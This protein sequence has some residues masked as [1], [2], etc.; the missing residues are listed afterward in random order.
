M[1]WFMV[2]TAIGVP[3]GIYAGKRRAV[4][5]RWGEIAEMF[6]SDASRFVRSTFSKM[7]GD[8]PKPDA[9]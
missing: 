4:G 9:N 5:R 8:D 7:F 2:G 3:L 1:Y 6:V